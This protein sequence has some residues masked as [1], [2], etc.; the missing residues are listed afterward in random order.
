MHAEVVNGM[1]V[2]AV[3]RRREARRR[4]LP[5]RQGPGAA[6]LRHCYRY[7]GHSLSDPRNEYRTKEEEAAWK[8]VDPIETYKKELLAAG[9]LD[10]EGLAAVKARR[11]PQRPR[12][13]ARR[14]RRRSRPKDVLKFMYTDT[15]SETSPPSSPRSKSRAAARNQARQRRNHLQGRP[16]GGARAGNGARQRVVFYGEDV[17]DYGGAFK[18]TKGL[19]EPSGATACST[20]RSAKPASAAPAAA[21]R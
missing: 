13:Q 15:K 3:P 4:A 2:L 11:R 17:A 14:R 20:R 10:A 9:V 16:Q 12:R 8:A 18:V 19:L 7:W 5:R 1:N 21:R 6:R